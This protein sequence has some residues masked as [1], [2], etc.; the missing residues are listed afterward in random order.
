MRILRAIQISICAAVLCATIVTA[1]RADQWDRKTIVTFGD[2]VEIPGQVL[3]AGTY[4]FKLL[5]SPDRHIVQIWNADESQILA[6]IVAIPNY[7]A[8]SS[9]STMFEF[10]ERPGNS[11]MALHSWFYPGDN[12]GVEF[13]YWQ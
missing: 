10:D 11:A 5:N 6:T 12:T 13:V 9:D 1:A 8:D 2:A 7:R 4:V 3:S